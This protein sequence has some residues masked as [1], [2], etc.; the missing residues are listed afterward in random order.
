MELRGVEDTLRASEEQ[1]RQIEAEIEAIRADRA[2]LNAALIETTAEGAG[3]RAAAAPPPT[4]GSPTL[5]GS[6]DAL[7]R[8]LER[9]RGVIADVLAALQRMGRNPPPA[10]LVR[11]RDMVEGG[12]R[13]DAARRG[14]SRTESGDRGAR[15]ATSTSSPTCASPSPASA[16]SSRASAASLAADK[17]RLPRWSTPASNL[18][19]TPRSALGSERS[20]RPNS[21]RQAAN[22]KDLIARHG[23]RDRRRP[24]RRGGRGA[25]RT[26]AAAADVDVARRRRARRGSGAAQAGD[27]LRRRQGASAAARRR[28]DRSRPSARRTTSAASRRASRSRRRRRRRSPRRSTAGSSFPDPTGLTGNS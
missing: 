10:I 24:R 7:A 4:R 26:E 17:T 28:R 27:R 18:W 8:S 12:A 2:R 3:R 5:N 20:A 22:L 11:P 6:A 9:R 14:D 13:G 21:P 15:A 16:T 23:E 1:R 25:R 19:P